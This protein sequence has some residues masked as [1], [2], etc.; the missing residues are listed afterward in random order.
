MHC[1]D[2]SSHFYLPCVINILSTQIWWEYVHALIVLSL[3]LTRWGLKCASF[4]CAVP[5]IEQVSIKKFKKKKTKL[6]WCLS[7]LPHVVVFGYVEFCIPSVAASRD[8]IT[9]CH[10]GSTSFCYLWLPPRPH[11]R[12]QITQ[13]GFF[14]FFFLHSQISMVATAVKS[15]LI[16]SN[17]M[18]VHMLKGKKTLMLPWLSCS[19]KFDCNYCTWSKIQ[20]NVYVLKSL[21]CHLKLIVWCCSIKSFF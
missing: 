12:P 4:D 10:F 2:F 18:F 6:L 14:F 19:S 8:H 15:S 17:S 11:L 3:L 1:Y 9:D 7:A 16:K 5:V 20:C 13:T 21:G